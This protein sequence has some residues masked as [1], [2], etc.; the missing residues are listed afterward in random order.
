MTILRKLHRIACL[1][2]AGFLIIFV[3][4]GLAL[5]HTQELDLDLHFVQWV[6]LLTAFGL[7]TPPNV[8][9]AVS[10]QMETGTTLIQID[11]S[12]YR[13]QPG[14]TEPIP[15]PESQM[16]GAIATGQYLFIADATTL[17][18]LDLQF[19]LVDRIDL[20]AE[21]LRLGKSAD[22][23][24]VETTNGRNRLDSTLLH[25]VPIE[26]G[27]DNNSAAVSWSRVNQPDQSTLEI[28]W[29]SHRTRILSWTRVLQEIHSGRILGSVGIFLADLATLALLALALSGLMLVRK[30]GN[31]P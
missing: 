3:C 19:N 25:W 7:D 17:T 2:A 12:L 14:S 21:M 1:F 24:I 23:P 28:A 31:R 20:P 29:K 5:Q 30:N 6:P 9:S 11:S 22:L 27:H 8:D 16:R 4:S 18:M 10:T 26:A 15:G 13:I